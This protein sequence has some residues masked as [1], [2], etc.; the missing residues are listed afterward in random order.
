MNQFETHIQE[1][2]VSAERLNLDMLAD[3]Q[4]IKRKAKKGKEDSKPI[5][6]I[7]SG[8]ILVQTQ[9]SST[10]SM[11]ARFSSFSTASDTDNSSKISSTVTKT[12]LTK[13]TESAGTVFSHSTSESSAQRVQREVSR[14]LL[15][16]R[17]VP[18]EG[19]P[20]CF[21]G[22]LFDDPEVEQYYEALV[23]TLKAAKRRGIVKFKG[24][25]LLKGMHDGVLIE[26]AQSIPETVQPIQAS[27][28]SS[29][30][31]GNN[32]KRANN[33]LTI[34]TKSLQPKHSQR[35]PIFSLPTSESP[36]QRVQRE[37]SRLLLD[38]RR[39][40]PEG[41][42]F[43]L[44]GPLF[45]DPEVEQYYEALVGTLKAAKRRGVVKFKGQMLLKGIHD[46]VLI[47]LVE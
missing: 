4:G 21:F 35:V 45:D 27:C 8:A 26:L 6:E 31:V 32:L 36:V 13:H 5:V 46:G 7:D 43:C 20:F 10:R 29:P 12:T 14:L 18:P 38:V 40:P 3:K 42:P 22:A 9:T 33:P 16:I 19:E 24:Q 37:V 2:K 11:P 30:V 47:E 23:G 41:K 17:R 39:V 34:E 1:D 28:P 25:M 15:D 44:F